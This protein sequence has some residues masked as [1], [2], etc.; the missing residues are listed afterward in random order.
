MYS[1]RTDS[2]I[3]CTVTWG[4]WSPTYRSQGSVLFTAWTL[5]PL[6]MRPQQCLAKVGK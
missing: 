4:F 3:Y 1:L 2:N 6:K 5:R